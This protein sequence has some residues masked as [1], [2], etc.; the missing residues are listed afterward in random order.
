MRTT[1]TT[2]ALKVLADWDQAQQALDERRQACTGIDDLCEF[3]LTGAIRPC[4]DF[5]IAL[6]EGYRVDTYRDSQAGI[7][8][9]RL[10][11]AVSAEHLFD[12]FLELLSV[13]GPVVDVVLETSHDTGAECHRDLHREEMDLTV[14]KSYCCEYEELLLH[15]GCTGL[16]V[17]DNG[18]PAEVQ[19]G[20]HK[21]LTVYA[22]DLEPFERILYQAD[23]PRDDRLKLITEGNHTHCSSPDYAAAFEQMCYRLGVACLARDPP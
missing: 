5:Q 13:L 19:F 2:A 21:Y 8:V 20:E 3:R 18:V 15:D 12:S 4:R 6:R 11:A 17:V 1:Q 23:V 7:Q 22:E 9:P 14:L 16:A 10:L